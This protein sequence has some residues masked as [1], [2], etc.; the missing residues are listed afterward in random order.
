MKV[1]VRAVLGSLGILFMFCLILVALGSFLEGLA[2]HHG[3]LGLSAALWFVI[4]FLFILGQEAG[5]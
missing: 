4:F 5:G 1:I 2:G 3:W